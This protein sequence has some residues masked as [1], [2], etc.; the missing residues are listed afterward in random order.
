MQSYLESQKDYEIKNGDVFFQEKKVAEIFRKWDMYKTFLKK[1]DIDWKKYVSR[2]FLPDYC[3]YV[4]QTN[5]LFIIEYKTQKTEGSVDEKLQTCDFKLYY[6]K[7]LLKKTGLDVKFVFL[8]N[9]GW[10]ND[11]KRKLKYKDVYK[12][13]RKRHC[14]YFFDEIPM[15]F[16]GLPT[17]NE[18][19]ETK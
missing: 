11:P 18:T 17:V 9:S 4:L 1:K 12:Y 8:L 7:K 2:R 6:Y 19:E 14:R 16:L 13:I 15:D 3:L 10:F 5:T